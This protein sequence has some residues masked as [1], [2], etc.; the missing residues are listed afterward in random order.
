[1]KIVEKT[2]KTIIEFKNMYFDSLSKNRNL[3]KRKSIDMKNRIIKKLRDNLPK[4][5]I[6]KEFR[7]ISSNC[8][9]LPI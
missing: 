7:I 1:M 5:N 9:L 6:N 2:F 3:L 4:M 8:S